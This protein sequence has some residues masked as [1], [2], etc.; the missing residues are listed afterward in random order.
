MAKANK[1]AKAT[2]E[3]SPTTEKT[4]KQKT[5]YGAK[6]TIVDNIKFD[7]KMEA[8]Y[9]L[10]LKDR[11]ENKEIKDFILQPSF[12]LQEAFI[13]VDGKSYLSSDENYNN[14]KKKFNP[15]IHRQIKYIADFLITF[16][17]NS[18]IVIDVKGR[19]T[20]DF[21]IK[22]KMYDLRYAHLPLQLVQS[23]IIDNKKVWLD[24]DE[25]KIKAKEKAKKNKEQNS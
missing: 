10:Y 9:Y 2:K 4:I 5:K 16:N 18:Q 17:D 7:S 12:I 6:K 25:L 14:L 11:K 13:I 15:P 24:Y 20:A 19:E 8:E 3:E 22:R 21:K 1:K 23:R